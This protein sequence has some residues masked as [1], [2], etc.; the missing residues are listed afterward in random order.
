M[1]CAL[2]P[3]P[4]TRTLCHTNVCS[5]S[6]FPLN[7][8][9]LRPQHYAIL[10]LKILTSLWGDIARQRC[11]DCRALKTRLA[12]GAYSSRSCCDTYMGKFLCVHNMIIHSITIES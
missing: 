7:S 4:E 3:K 6:M 10:Q 1:M 12:L 9:H 8:L 11:S 5:H 2:L